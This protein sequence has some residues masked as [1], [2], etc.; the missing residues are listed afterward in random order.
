M[1]NQ[2]DMEALTR[3]REL[4]ILDRVLTDAENAI[5]D[6]G[7]AAAYARAAEVDALIV[8]LAAQPFGGEVW[9]RSQALAKFTERARAILALGEAKG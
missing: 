7:M 9:G 4:G 6:A 5:Y 1:T 3:A 8:D 2:A